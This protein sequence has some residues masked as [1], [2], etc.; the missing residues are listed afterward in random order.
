MFNI[1]WCLNAIA[2]QA[3]RIEKRHEEY[4]EQYIHRAGD[5]VSRSVCKEM[6][7]ATFL[8]EQQCV[9]GSVAQPVDR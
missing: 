2:D 3:Q 8:V 5:S 9:L 1:S 6:K 7:R 4:F